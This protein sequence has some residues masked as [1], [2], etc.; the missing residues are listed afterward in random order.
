MLNRVQTV[1]KRLR[2]NLSQ[3]ADQAYANVDEAKSDNEAR[4]FSREG[5]AYGR[6]E[7]EVRLEE[8]AAEERAAEDAD[9][10]G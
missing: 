10:H 5:L 7:H 9:T 6:A 4:G 3:K 8:A 1:L 2:E